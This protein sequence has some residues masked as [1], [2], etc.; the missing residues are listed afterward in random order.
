MLAWLKG[1]YCAGL[2]A[3]HARQQV[4]TRFVDTT[5]AYHTRTR[6]LRWWVRSVG[7]RGSGTGLPFLA[8]APPCAWHAGL[9]TRLCLG[10]EILARGRGGHQALNCEGRRTANGGGWALLP[11]RGHERVGLALPTAERAAWTGAACGRGW[12][13]PGPRV[14]PP[15]PPGSAARLTGSVSGCRTNPPN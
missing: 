15:R 6:L 1:V 5:T 13:R 4:G 14:T 7:E 12:A 8:G 9:G 11:T 3:I 10:P 2:A